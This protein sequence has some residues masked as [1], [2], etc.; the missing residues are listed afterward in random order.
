MM[1]YAIALTLASA[2]NTPSEPPESWRFNVWLDDKTIGTHTFDLSQSE[3]GD[4]VMVSEARFDVKVWFFTAFEYRHRSEERYADG[5]LRRF[6]ATTSANDKTRLVTGQLDQD[7]F[8]V[9]TPKA[10]T[11][12]QLPPCILPFTYW[13]PDFLGESHLL[14]VQNGEYLPVTVQSKGLDDWQTSEGMVPARR[15]AIEAKDLQIE[16]WYGMDGDWVGLETQTRGKTLR[17]ERT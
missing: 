6:E 15:Y 11:A 9:H 3:S 1:L 13:N 4:W 2:I 12:Q 16:L 8:V 7:A 17:Y 5:C 14:N 10:D